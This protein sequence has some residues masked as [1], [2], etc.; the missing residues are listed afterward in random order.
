MRSLWTSASGLHG[1]QARL[2][3]IAHNMANLNTKGYKAQDVQFKDLLYVEMG[4]QAAVNGLNERNT[5]AGLRIGHGVY[6]ANVKHSF[7]PG[8]LERTDLKLDVAIQGEGFFS[9]GIY[10]ATGRTIQVGFTRDGSFKVGQDRA[11]NHFLVDSGGRP[12]LNRQAQPIELTGVDV[13]TVK[14]DAAGT[15]SGMI[16]GEM[17]ELGQLEV[18]RIQNPEANLDAIGEN[19]YVLDAN[20]GVN[21]VTAGVAG[22][23]GTSLLQGSLEMSNVDMAAQMTDMIMAQ[24]A[25]GMNSRAIQVAD[26]MMGIANNLRNG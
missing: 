22:T 13:N 16:G 26:Q 7:T 8:P 23:E 15:I 19:L 20:A 12:V 18:A 3:A 21:V 5:P 24:R 10:D 11:G 17:T 4:Q 14:I 25:Y 9:V 1:Q 6:A 2:D